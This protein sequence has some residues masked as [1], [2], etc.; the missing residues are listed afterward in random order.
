M[1]RQD[2]SVVCSK[3]ERT[4]NENCLRGKRCPKCGSYGP[5][6]IDVSTTILLSDEGSCDAKN[7]AIE[8][9]DES[10]AKCS[11]CS[12]SSRWGGFN[13]RRSR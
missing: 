11:N 9:N 8:F 6:E 12:Y 4:P 1:R 2:A 10:R 5:F 7:G 13:V 3:E